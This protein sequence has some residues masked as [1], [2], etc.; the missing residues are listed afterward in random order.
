MRRAEPQLMRSGWRQAFDGAGALAKDAH[1]Q[2]LSVTVNGEEH[3]IRYDTAQPQMLVDF[4]RR[5]ANLP[6]TKVGCSAGG[7]GACT[8]MLT[9][10]QMTG[11]RYAK[12]K[13]F[14]KPAPA[15]GNFTVSVSCAGCANTTKATIADVTFGGKLHAHP[16]LPWSC[17]TAARGGCA[18]QMSG[19]AP[20]K[21]TCGCL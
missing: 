14:L 4:L 20:D 13:A 11:G 3:S 1:M 12:W 7:C 18:A 8:V 9:E 10:Q 6:G 19:S 15:G 2:M 21:A 16:R 17:L 5:D